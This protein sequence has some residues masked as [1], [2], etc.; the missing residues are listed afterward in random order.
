MK[1]ALL[2][3]NLRARS[4][5]PRVKAVIQKALAA[6]LD[7]K[8]ADT[9]ARNHATELAADAAASGCDLVVSFGGDGTM[10]EVLN[11][12][13][14]TEAALAILPGG[15][16]NVMCRTLGMPTDIVEATGLLLNRIK[17]GTTRQVN[18]GRIDDRYFLMSCGLGLDAATVRRTERNPVAK[19]RYR[20]WFFLYAALRTAFTEYRRRHPYIYMDTGEV[21]EK[22]LIAIVSNIKPFTFFK[23]LPVIVTPQAKLEAGLDVFSMR[24]FPMTYIPTLLWS[25]FA[26]GSHIRSKNATYLH[27]IA[28]ATFR[29]ET[30]EPFP[31]QLDGEYIGERRE[32]KVELVTDGL[33]ILS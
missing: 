24:K 10:N 19:R 12:L 21:N 20:D 31:V 16:A 32:L 15:M 25:T 2:I 29:S 14:G 23:N 13:V 3:T 11:G 33:K 22:V 5:S 1:R 26:S 28:A 18:L 9:R 30:G 8:V 17:T 4:V 6:C 27:N 7:L